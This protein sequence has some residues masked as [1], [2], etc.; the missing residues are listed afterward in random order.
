MLLVTDLVILVAGLVLLAAGLVL[1]VAGLVLL[2]AGLVLLLEYILFDRRV[3][4]SCSNFNWSH[5]LND[6]A[7]GLK[8]Y[9]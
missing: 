4:L 7:L 6:H 3:V 9:R 1:L 8:P 2:A 5:V